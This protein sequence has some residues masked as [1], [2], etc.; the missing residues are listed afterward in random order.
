MTVVGLVALVLALGAAVGLVL[1]VVGR[2]RETSHAALCRAHLYHIGFALRAYHT[3]YGTFP[4]AV[5]H[6]PRGRPPHSW[7]VRITPYLD[8][9]GLYDA[10]NFAQPWD[11]PDNRPLLATTR[12]FVCPAHRRDYG[13]TPFTSYVAVTGPDAPWGRSIAALGRPPGEV[14]LVVETTADVPWTAPVD[15]PAGA[16]LGAASRPAPGLPLPG[17]AHDGRG[18]HV[19]YADGGVRWVPLA[20]DWRARVARAAAGRLLPAPADAPRPATAP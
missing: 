18:F 6:D 3:V 19:L 15:L 11:G 8:Y 5:S 13:T 16:I 12:D 4:P 14:P 1:R 7:R 17:S 2:A 10:Y 9:A 20:G